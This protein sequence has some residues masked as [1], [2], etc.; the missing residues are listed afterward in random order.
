[1]EAGIVD[2]STGDLLQ[3]P[4]SE[5]PHPMSGWPRGEEKW[6]VCYS[7]FGENKTVE[8]RRESRLLIV[9][10]GDAASKDDDGSY[11]HT[12]YFV[13][14]KKRFRRVGDEVGERV[15]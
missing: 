6:V 8:T 9:R 4:Y 11:E 5:K 12:S 14:E 15:F 10:C 2:L 7:A 1:V 3:I 13:F